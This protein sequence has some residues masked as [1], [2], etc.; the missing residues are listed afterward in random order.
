M[1]QR[2][3]S[4]TSL[5]WAHQL[6][7]EH[8]H[9]LDRMKALEATSKDVVTR[10][11]Q[12]EVTAA[13]AR[14]SMTRVADIVARIA[15][16]EEDDDDVRQWITK[17]EEERQAQ[18]RNGDDKLQSL[19]R[20]VGL[21]GAEYRRLEADEEEAKRRDDDMM[22]RLEQLEVAQEP[23]KKAADKLIRKNDP[24]DKVLSRRLDAFESRRNE[25][26]SKIAALLQKI[27]ALE[28]SNHELCTKIQ[29]MQKTIESAR[30][31]KAR[32]PFPQHPVHTVSTGTT[33]M[34]S[35]TVSSP[36]IQVARSPVIDRRLR[37]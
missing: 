22:R 9:L 2:P 36:N 17:L 14:E 28:S 6:K 3:T 29:Q 12:T 24:V 8:A 10:M 18:A 1:V 25:D 34:D 30:T 35:P 33:Q 31:P 19:S 7:K 16:I 27:K 21:L 11:A 20:K 32:M 13:S 37:E 4:P 26:S 15:A 5:L 23:D